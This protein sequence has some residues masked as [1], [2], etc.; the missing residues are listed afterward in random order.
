MFYNN[1]KVVQ[2]IIELGANVNIRNS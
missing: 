1:N 2:T